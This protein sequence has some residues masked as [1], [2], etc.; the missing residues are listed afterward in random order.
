[1]FSQY[2]NH[3]SPFRLTTTENTHKRWSSS[4]RNWPSWNDKRKR[5]DRHSWQRSEENGTRNKEDKWNIRGSKK[6]SDGLLKSK[7]GTRNKKITLSVGGTISLMTFNT[8]KTFLRTWVRILRTLL[9]PWSMSKR[10]LSSSLMN[11]QTDQDKYS[12]RWWY[13]NGSSICGS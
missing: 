6:S 2:H 8:L 11:C 9:T 13:S 1:M 10:T 12:K 3:L 5:R 4:K 7:E